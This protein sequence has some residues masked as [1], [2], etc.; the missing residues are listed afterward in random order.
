M[1]NEHDIIARSTELG[2]ITRSFKGSLE[3]FNQNVDGEINRIDGAIVSANNAGWTGELYDEFRAI[4]D[5]RLAGLRKL[6]QKAAELAA[7][8]ELC[9]Q[10]YDVIIDYYRKGGMA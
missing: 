2:K 9:A 10:D 4:F 5:E 3:E 1:S 6:S 7:E 8:L